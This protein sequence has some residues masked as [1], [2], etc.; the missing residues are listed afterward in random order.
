MDC[1]LSWLAVIATLCLFFGL[2]LALYSILRVHSFYLFFHFRG[3]QR[4]FG[5][6]SSTKGCGGGIG[7]QGCLFP[8]RN[9]I[10]LFG[11]RIVLM[12][13]IM[14]VRFFLVSMPVAVIVR[15]FLVRMSMTVVV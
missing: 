7:I 6:P 10:V 4:S 14:P 13:V 5:R 3:I 1:R 11:G 12:L 15:F 8:R 9:V 2:H